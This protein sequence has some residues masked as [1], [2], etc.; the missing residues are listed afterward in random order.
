M[1]SLFRCD[2]K[3]SS[4]ESWVIRFSSPFEYR[5]TECKSTSDKK[6]P[7]L[8]WMRMRKRLYL[9]KYEHGSYEFW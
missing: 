1:F 6:K 5:T 4:V 8:L 9:D 2:C 3:S 7:A